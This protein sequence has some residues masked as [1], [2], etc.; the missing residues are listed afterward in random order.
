MLPLANIFMWLY[1]NTS[2]F[3]W[4]KQIL[5]S[6]S[7]HLLLNLHLRK[8]HS[9]LPSVHCGKL[10]SFFSDCLILHSRHSNKSRGSFLCLLTPS[11]WSHS[12]LFPVPQTLLLS[13][14]S[15]NTLALN[16]PLF[17]YKLSSPYEKLEKIYKYKSNYS[18][19]L[20]QS[21]NAFKLLT[22]LH[23]L[24]STTFGHHFAFFLYQDSAKQIKTESLVLMTC[25]QIQTVRSRILKRPAFKITD[26][27]QPVEMNQFSLSG[28]TK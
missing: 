16:L 26:F 13:A 25:K 14:A 2:L 5:I 9:Y 19:L 20:Q 7:P 22:T 8:C 10:K 1:N 12:N 21:T 28:G 18:Y 15:T 17:I 27:H 11:V 3:T 6:S 24:L 4:P 23:D